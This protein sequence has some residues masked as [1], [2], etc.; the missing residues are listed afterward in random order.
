[1][2]ES[3]EGRGIQLNCPGAYPTCCVQ[4]SLEGLAV[5]TLLQSNHIN[6][7]EGAAGTSTSFDCAPQASLEELIGGTG[8]ASL[9]VYDEAALCSSA[10]KIL[11]GVVY[12]WLMDVTTHQNYHADLQL[13]H[14]YR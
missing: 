11:R 4:L 6:D 14:F 7:H 5:N 10:F 9:S 8:N 3:E 2:T 12:A 1:M 13:Q